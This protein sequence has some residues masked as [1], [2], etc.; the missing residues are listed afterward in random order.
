METITKKCGNCKKALSV[1]VFGDNGKGECFKTCD[2]CRAEGRARKARVKF[3]KDVDKRERIARED[4][5]SL[6]NEEKDAFTIIPCNLNTVVSRHNIFFINEKIL[7]YFGDEIEIGTALDPGLDTETQTQSIS[8][9]ITVGGVE[10]EFEVNLGATW[11]E[12]RENLHRAAGHHAKKASARERTAERE[13]LAQ[14]E[15][16]FNMNHNYMLDDAMVMKEENRHLFEAHICYIYV[17]EK[18]PA[19]KV[20]CKEPDDN[21]FKDFEGF[22]LDFDKCNIQYK[23]GASLGEI[24]E[25]LTY[26]YETYIKKG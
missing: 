4:F 5:D 2:A 18:W 21:E 1:E 22:Y 23:D 19:L 20:K 25:N 17:P 7:D 9:W 15:K 13:A 10:N 12:I 26:I 16:D 3:D 24:K 6:S 14:S 8:V 11:G